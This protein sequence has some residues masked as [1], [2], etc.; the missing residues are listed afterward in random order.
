MKGTITVVFINIPCLQPGQVDI[1]ERLSASLEM[2]RSLLGPDKT[3]E[4]RFS[5]TEPEDTQELDTA[6]TVP[7]EGTPM[8]SFN[9]YFASIKKSK[10]PLEGF[11]NGSVYMFLSLF[12]FFVI[13]SIFVI[14]YFQAPSKTALEVRSSESG[15]ATSAEGRISSAPLS[16]N[17]REKKEAEQH[18]VRIRN[19]LLAARCRHGMSKAVI[20]DLYKF[21][22]VDFQK[23]MAYLFKNGGLPGHFETLR[24]QAKRTLPSIHL[25]YTFTALDGTVSTGHGSAL[26]AWLTRDRDRL[27]RMSAYIQLKDLMKLWREEH[28]DAVPAPGVEWTCEVSTDGVAESGHGRRKFHFVSIAFGGCGTPLPWYIYEFLPGHG[29][30]IH[31]YLTPVVTELKAQGVHLNGFICDGKEQNLVRGQ[32]GNN[33]YYGCGWCLTRGDYQFR[34]V[35]YPFSILTTRP[36]TT[37]LFRRLFEEHPEYFETKETLEWSANARFGIIRYSPLLDLDYFD[38]VGH[39]PLDG[40]HLIHLGITKDTWKRLF[41][42]TIVIPSAKERDAIHEQF[43]N[44]IVN[45]KLPT[46][47]KRRT[48]VI[49]PP[50]MKASE[51]QVV[52]TFCF[53]ELA[54]SLPKK[55]ANLATALLLYVFIVRLCYSDDATVE[56]I[57]ASWNVPKMQ[58]DFYKVYSKVFGPGCFTFNLHSFYHILTSRATTGPLHCTSTHRFEALYAK[59]RRSY[60]SNTASTPKQL[61]F[62][63][64][65]NEMH[66]HKCFRGRNL[67]FSDKSSLKNDDTLIYHE[68]AFYAIKNVVGTTM[69][70]NR[71]LTYK[72]NTDSLY[73]LP[74]DALGVHIFKDVR[75]EEKVFDRDDVSVKA[76]RCGSIISACFPDWLV[77]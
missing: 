40:M 55:W 63:F 73:K 69:Y 66:S 20:D 37:A 76:V 24:R 70:C 16:P 13:A 67:A 59:T 60:A 1:E 28:P 30:S 56:A 4:G 27:L 39:V 25:S 36:R 49:N 19:K 7:L 61:L 35:I 48:H 43:M 26:P 33:G 46:E 3:R 64:Y 47:F 52:D 15:Q 2:R 22:C 5:P 68:G 51:W 32:V 62:N 42:G 72:L 18:V 38:I 44:D 14:V 17:S 21:F 23:P 50:E 65:A 11:L 57:M 29:P 8:V 34:K 74:W 10:I 45:T 6:V 58:A 75:L 12:K 53:L 31:D 9:V 41:E 54:V 71:L 77:R